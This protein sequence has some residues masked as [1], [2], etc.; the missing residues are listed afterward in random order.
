MGWLTILYYIFW[1]LFV[2]IYSLFILTAYRFYTNKIKITPYII[3][4]LMNLFLSAFTIFL[5]IFSIAYMLFGVIALE[6]IL[7]LSI[8]IVTAVIPN[9]LLYRLYYKKKDKLT[10]KQYVLSSLYGFLMVVLFLVQNNL[11]H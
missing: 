1:I 6:A 11:L 4:F 2:S 8:A 9:I 3:P 5:A 10:K 7:F